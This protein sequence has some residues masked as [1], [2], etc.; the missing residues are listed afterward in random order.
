MKG[1]GGVSELTFFVYC[2]NKFT[3]DRE[4]LVQMFSDFLVVVPIEQLWVEDGGG[5][6]R[7]IMHDALWCFAKGCHHLALTYITLICI[8]CAFAYD[9]CYRFIFL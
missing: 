7:D 9:V 6:V 1:V 3:R 5:V 4:K 8:T 2:F